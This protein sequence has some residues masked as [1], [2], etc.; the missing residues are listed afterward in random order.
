M[1][2]KMVE[3]TINSTGGKNDCFS[4]MITF[5]VRYDVP[6]PHEASADS[7]EWK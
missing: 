1:V 3:N 7:A 2:W 4:N 5:Y 6:S